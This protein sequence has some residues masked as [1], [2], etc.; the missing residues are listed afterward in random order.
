M[1]DKSNCIIIKD[2][3][4]KKIKCSITGP[5]EYEFVG[6]DKETGKPIYIEHCAGSNKQISDD[7][8]QEE[9]RKKNTYKSR[10]F[11]DERDIE[12][13]L[14]LAKKKM[15]KVNY[16]DPWQIEFDKKMDEDW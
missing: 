7:G 8:W 16:N 13:G 3:E 5:R 11:V 6:C 14:K 9:V 10:G 2:S 4:L 15:P 12:E 1:I